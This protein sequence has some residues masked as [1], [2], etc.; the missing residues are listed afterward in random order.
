MRR[1][2]PIMSSYEIYN[3]ILCLIVFVSLTA[4]FVFLIGA[5]I[6]LTLSNINGG[7]DDENIKNEYYKKKDKKE[8]KATK[9]LDKAFPILVCVLLGVA[10]CFS[11]Y[12]RF[13]QN[14][15][16]GSVPTIKVVETGSME[17]KHKDNS[18]LF[19]NN[20]DDQIETFDLIVLHELPK[21]EDL[22]LYDIVVYEVNGYFIIH[23][24]VGIE[25]PNEK[26]PDERWFVLR[27]DANKQADE[28]PVKYSQ[29][30]SIYRGERVPFVGS[31]VFFMQSPA[32]MLCFLLV[33]FAVVATPIAE[34]QISNAKKS[35]LATILDKQD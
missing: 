3:L 26:H 34:K 32:G 7:L 14:G 10:L 25:E 2:L 9:V 21:E 19:S 17:S 18:Y 27:G 20:L 8:S 11:L 5:I 24:I 12:S 4:M 30:K 22:K 35:R 15:K 6:K 28:F 13:T 29:M 33:V 1:H 31:F 23:R 16:V